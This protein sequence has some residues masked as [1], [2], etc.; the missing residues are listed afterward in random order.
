V[1]YPDELLVEGER[2]LLHRRP[3]WRLLVGPV[4]AFLL[5]LGVAGYLAAL[6]RG[7]GWQQWGWPAIAAVAAVLV[8]W[9]AAA[10]V[11]RW[12]TTHLVVTTRRMLV[13]EGV[14]APRSLEIPLDRIAD[15]H[16]RYGR[17][18]RLVGCGALAVRGVDGEVEFADVPG[19]D[20][21]RTLLRQ[22][23]GR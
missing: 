23:A 10:P 9:L 22:A 14:R 8:A 18:G 2:V 4:L 5:T 15:V 7:Q 3:H 21:V 1:A 16:T 17:L 12:R 13:R 6:A 20:R 19:A 11:V